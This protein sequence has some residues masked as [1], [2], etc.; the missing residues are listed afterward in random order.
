MKKKDKNK[1]VLSYSTK[2]IQIHTGKQ[3]LQY[4]I[5]KQL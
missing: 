4:Q 5:L 3:Q 1:L 2:Y